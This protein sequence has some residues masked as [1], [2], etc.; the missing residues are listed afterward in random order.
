M[1]AAPA[2]S[3]AKVTISSAFDE[4]AVDQD[5]IRA[6]APIG[7]GAT[8]RLIHSPA[9]DQRLDARDDQKFGSRCVSFPAA[10]LPANSAISAS[11]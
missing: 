6:R 1:A 7:F 10:I 9:G 5:G 11:G 3:R 4:L 8:Q 2:H